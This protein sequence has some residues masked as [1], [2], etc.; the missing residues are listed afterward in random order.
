MFVE[1]NG[2]LKMYRR[3]EPSPVFAYD[4]FGVVDDAIA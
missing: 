1:P 2:M 4:V 3:T